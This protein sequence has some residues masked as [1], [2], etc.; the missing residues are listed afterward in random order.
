MLDADT[1]PAAI[2]PAVQAFTGALAEHVRTH[3]NASLVAHEQGVL[4]VW[5][6]AAPAVLTGVLQAATDGLAAPEPR[7]RS[8]SACPTCARRRRPQSGQGRSRTVLTRLGPVTLTRP[9]HHCRPCQT[10]WSPSDQVLGLAPR[11]RT[12]PGLQQGCTRLK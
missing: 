1:L 4:D 7:R 8:R 2:V 5:R 6:A 9:W 3:P 11:Q 10:G 12:S